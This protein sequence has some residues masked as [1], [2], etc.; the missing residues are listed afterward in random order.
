M[1]LFRS[2]AQFDDTLFDLHAPFLHPPVTLAPDTSGVSFVLRGGYFAVGILAVSL[3][4]FERGF[5]DSLGI[6]GADGTAEVLAGSSLTY[7]ATGMVSGG[8]VQMIHSQTAAGAGWDL[9]GIRLG[10]A[11]VG[12]ALTS[13]DTTDD[14]AVLVQALAG[15]DRVILSAFGDTFHAGG[16]R[17]MVMGNAGADVLYGEGGNDL[18]DGGTGADLV[19]GGLGNDAL[20]GGAGRDTLVGGQGD[21]TLFAGAGTQDSVTGGAGADVFVFRPEG[22]LSQTNVT[23]FQRGMDH[24]DLAGA[25]AGGDTVAFADLDIHQVARGAMITCAF[26]EGQQ[27]FKMLLLGVKAADLTADDFP[28]YTVFND[29]IFSSYAHFQDQWTYWVF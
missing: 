7:D 23:D 13:A 24:I 28:V 29:P 17:D 14:R 25:K 4:R 11:G 2:T 26:N 6:S 8:K 5:G 3:A 27:V 10:G 21:D 15:N 22:A 20:Y 18:M 16:G 1:A 9:V 19:S 12:A